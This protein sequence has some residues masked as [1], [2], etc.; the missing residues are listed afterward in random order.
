MNLLIIFFELIG[1]ILI[2]HFLFACLPLND[3]IL[4]PFFIH[5]TPKFKVSLRLFIQ[6]TVVKLFFIILILSLNEFLKG[7]RSGTP[8]ASRKS[9]TSDTG[10]QTNDNQ[11][12]GDEQGGRNKRNNN[13]NNQRMQQ[14]HQ[15]RE[16]QDSGRI[17]DQEN[18]NRGGYRV[19]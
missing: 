13:N 7:S 5:T 2:Y 17:Q 15:Q 6:N 10:V 18:Q 8:N 11:R 12:G 1:F 19:S 4:L 14:Q 3:E 9:P 16:R